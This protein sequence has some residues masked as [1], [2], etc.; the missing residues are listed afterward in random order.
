MDWNARM[1]TARPAEM[2]AYATHPRSLTNELGFSLRERTVPKQNE[3]LV[4]GATPNVAHLL[5][6]GHTCRYRMLQDGRRQITA[7]LVPGDICDLEAILA[8]RSSY[9]VSTL[10]RCTLGEIPLSRF[11]APHDPAL[12]TS[13]QRRLRRDEAIAR[14]WIV[15]LGRRDGIERTAHL[16]CELRWRLAEVGQA[17]EDS[18]KLR[19]TQHDLA[20][21][22]G[23]TSV[24]VNRVLMHLRAEGL[25]HLKA[26]QLTI[27][28]RTRLKH[29]AQFDPA[30]LVQ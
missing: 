2:A 7:I 6:A 26:G 1:L 8:G 11:T 4:P 13:L 16:F 18:C 29:L 9:A 22:L 12:A 14:E 21:A 24:H 10:T 23:L 15:S 30:Y 17:T 20:D 19:I 25:I 28:D 3:I 27:I 5:L